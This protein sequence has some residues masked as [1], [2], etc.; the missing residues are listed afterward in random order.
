MQTRTWLWTACF[1]PK[2]SGWPHLGV[3][4]NQQLQGGCLACASKSLDP[5]QDMNQEKIR[6]LCPIKLQDCAHEQGPAHAH[7][8]QSPLDMV[9]Q[10]PWV[11]KP[12]PFIDAAGDDVID[13]RD[14]LGCQLHPLPLHVE[15]HV[16]RRPAHRHSQP[17]RH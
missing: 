7:M 15:N 2:G 1:V 16:A 11:H 9:G 4:L 14:L 10:G 17:L 13:D 6:S 3:C 12:T 5:E 8:P